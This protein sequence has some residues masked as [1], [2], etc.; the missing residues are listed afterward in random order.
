MSDAC[1]P[2]VGN[3]SLPYNCSWWTAVHHL[4]PYMTLVSVVDEQ[5]RIDTFSLI[6]NEIG[7]AI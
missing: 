4:T 6:P 3:I 5:V 7:L 1:E 2:D